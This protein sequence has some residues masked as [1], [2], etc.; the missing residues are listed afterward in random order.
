MRLSM[1]LSLAFLLAGALPTARSAGTTPPPESRLRL[2]HT[3]TGARLNVV[4]RRGDSY[5]PEGLAKLDRFLRDHRTGEVHH[6]DPQ[7]FDLLSQVTASVGR[8]GAELEIIC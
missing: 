3:H 2:F 1:T 8:A 5:V 7:V 6:Y 4:Y